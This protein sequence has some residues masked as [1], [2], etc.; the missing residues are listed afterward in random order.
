M[1]TPATNAQAMNASRIPARNRPL[2]TPELVAVEMP[3]KNSDR[4]L[5]VATDAIIVPIIA[6]ENTCPRNLMVETVPDAVPSLDF[7]TEPI[8]A[9]VLGA[10]NIPIPNPMMKR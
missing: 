5:L 9:L 7:G 8:T 2:L 4:M 1:P 6:R 3:M 10:E